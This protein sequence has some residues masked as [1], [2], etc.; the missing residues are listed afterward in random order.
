MRIPPRAQRCIE[1]IDTMVDWLGFYMGDSPEFRKF[2]KND[3][4]YLEEYLA[5]ISE[6]HKLH[7]IKFASKLKAL[8]K[9]ELEEKELIIKKLKKEL[10]EQKEE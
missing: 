4:K 5:E 1:I 9:E 8:W 3:I 7:N 2:I 10:D 6:E